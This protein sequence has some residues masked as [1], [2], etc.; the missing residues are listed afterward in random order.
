[1]MYLGAYGMCF[2]LSMIGRIGGMIMMCLLLIAFVVFAIVWMSKNSNLRKSVD[3]SQQQQST[4]RAMEIL[5]ERYAS[6]E[7]TDEEY[8]KKKVELKKV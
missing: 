8:A 7:I 6:G 3:E 1:M 4:N 5:N 2:G